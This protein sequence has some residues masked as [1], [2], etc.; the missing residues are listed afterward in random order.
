MRNCAVVLILSALAVAGIVFAQ[1]KGEAGGSTNTAAG[2][3]SAS[4]AKEKPLLL[5]DGP[6]PLLLDD[7]KGTNAPA[8]S[9]P[10]SA[11]NQGL[12]ATGDL[13]LLDDLNP[14]PLLAT[15]NGNGTHTGPAADNSRCQVCHL[16]MFFEEIT[17]T[18]AKGNIGCAKCHGECDAHIADESWAS[19]GNGTAPEVMYPKHTINALCRDCH[20]TV[21]MIAT[22]PSKPCPKLQG[23]RTTQKY[24]TDCHG[25]HRLV[26]RK[27]KWK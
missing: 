5:D 12:R 27:C 19:G 9:S 1:S 6:A 20:K 8:K 23:A 7:E 14:T 2:K 16:N 11:A 10:P 21:K 24:C 15:G 26:E 17:L 25:K 4:P 22:S 18:H 3:S 13:L